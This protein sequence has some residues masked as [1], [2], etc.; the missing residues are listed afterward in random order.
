[1]SGEP[2]EQYE[3]RRHRRVCEGASVRLTTTTK[4]GPLTD[5]T[6]PRMRMHRLSV[7]AERDSDC[8]RSSR[9][10][11]LTDRAARLSLENLPIGITI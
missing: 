3:A 6:K 9:P 2:T 1:M 4:T 5:L 8:W 7:T 10:K 11:L